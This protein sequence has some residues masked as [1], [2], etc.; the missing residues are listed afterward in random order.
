MFG[1]GKQGRKHD[2]FY[3]CLLHVVSKDILGTNCLKT[4]FVIQGGHT[5]KVKNELECE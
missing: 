1:G 3:A 2:M 5:A 4:N